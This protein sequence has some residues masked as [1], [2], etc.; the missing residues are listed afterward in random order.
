MLAGFALGV[1]TYLVTV[2]GGNWFIDTQYLSEESVHRRSMAAVESLQNYIR[3]NN[4]ASRDTEQIARWSME[5]KDIY[6]L[7][8]KNRH[9]ALEAGWWGIDDGSSVGNQE[10]SDQSTLT[11]YPVSFRD[12]LFQAVVYDFSDAKLYDAVQIIAIVL[13]CALFALLML[14]YNSRITHAIVGVSREI[15][16]IGR[17]NLETQME[18]GGNDELGRLTGSVD[19]MRVSLIRKTQEE[20]TALKKNS[21]LITAM[22]HD[23]RNPLTA[24]LGY[25]DLARG[26]Q[27][28]SPDEL[29]QYLDAAYSKAEQLKSLT[30]E[31]FRYSLVFG[32]RELNL[33]M[34]EYD[35][36][37]LL[38]QLLFEPIMALEQR[39]FRVH[40]TQPEKTCRI[41]LDVKYFKRVLDNLFDNLRKYADPAAPVAIAVLVEDGWLQLCIGNTRKKDPG[42]VESNK[43][44]LKTCERILSQMGGSLRRYEQGEQFSVE[45]SLPVLPEDDAETAANQP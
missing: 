30:D 5:Q 44:G 26:G 15:Q 32:G 16:E 1:L 8:Y 36:A 34:Q 40:S 38:E 35:A 39:G 18:T 7:F 24:L 42:V 31:L 20:Q 41:R 28:R 13:A 19:A 3:E 6:I 10:L 43:I 14:L 45:L 21:E 11:L 37:I 9:L 4:L 29:K 33:D 25:L 17:G 2:Q 12:G 27:Y 22:S 23:I